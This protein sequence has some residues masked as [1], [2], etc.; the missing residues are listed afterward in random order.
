MP[1]QKYK[2]D[3]VKVN[4]KIWSQEYFFS[5]KIVTKHIDEKI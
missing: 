1:L 2:Q 5:R 3:E 4:N